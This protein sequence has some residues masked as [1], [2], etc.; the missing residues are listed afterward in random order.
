MTNNQ[1]SW[2]RRHKIATGLLI[3]FGLIMLIG[4]FQDA[5]SE[6]ANGGEKLEIVNTEQQVAESVQLEEIT[7]RDLYAQ[8]KGN[9]I[10]ADQKYD[11]KEIIVTG[12]IE[13]FTVAL[14]S[15]SVTLATGDLLGGV[16]CLLDDTEDAKAASLSKGSNVR[17]QGK[18]SGYLLGVTMSDCRIL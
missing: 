16:Q 2:F 1:K 3:F 5:S 7:A 10:A 18:V 8:F 6:L 13:N 9:E 11:G 17:L 14:G 12:V 15:N 4:A